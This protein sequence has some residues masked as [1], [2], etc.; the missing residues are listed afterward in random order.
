[1][2]RDRFFERAVARKVARVFEYSFQKKNKYPLDFI[3]AWME[4]DTAIQTTKCNGNYLCQGYIWIYNTFE[5]ECPSIKEEDLLNDYSDAM[6]W[7][8]YVLQLFVFESNKLPSEI[9]ETYDMERILCA[10]DTLH[11][12]SANGAIER[13]EE[14]FRR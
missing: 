5:M 7:M 3:K 1:M 6:Y 13:I 14:D 12:L 8:G 2:E 11:T 9:V 10:Y 4:S